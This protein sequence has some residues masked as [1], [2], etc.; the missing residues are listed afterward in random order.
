MA[1]YDY[2]FTSGDTVTPTKLNSARTV[3][4]IVNADIKSDAAIA[5]SKL[6]TGALPTAITVASANLVDGTIVDA[7]VN[8]TAAIALSK[9]ATGALP[10][11]ITV[12]SANIVDGTIVNA[13][14]NASAAIAGSKL[15]DGAINNAKVDASAAIAHTKLANITAG[16]VLMGN[17]S[18]VPTATALS[19]DVTVNSSGVTA[20]GPG[21][22]VDADINGSAAI[23]LSKL[24]T[25]ALPTAITVASA[26]L[27]D[28]TIVNA[29]ISA[30]AAIADSKLATISTAAKVSNSA[31]TAT[32]ANTASAI[33]ARDAS[34]NFSAGTITASL[35]GNVTGNLTGTA[36]AIADGSVSTAA[37]LA[38]GVVTAAKLS[39]AQ[40][41]AAPVFGVRAWV[42]FDATRDSSG[43]SNTDN[44][45]RFIRASGNVASVLKTATGVFTITFTTA[46]PDEHYAISGFA[47]W[48]T[49]NPAGIVG[50]NNAF[51]PDA[52]S[53]VVRVF[54]STTA[55]E[56][57]V[58]HNHVM[59]VR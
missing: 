46:M 13:D 2:T 8:A 47:N 29:D 34:G 59:F 18:N 31:T 44:T 22:I 12:A 20:I 1:S 58:S 4:D 36:S 9:L 24:A 15:A 55:N 37:K 17:A 16:Q 10:A 27:V 7:D 26:N 38:S 33:V 53:C 25:G 51:A 28:G 23:A 30:S 14:I 52:G 54:G 5:L 49:S 6:A 35:T 50:Q 56:N 40:T 57:N 3:K 43:A 21:V 39:G 48:T 11:A 32:S 41:G 19:G 45:N 42:N